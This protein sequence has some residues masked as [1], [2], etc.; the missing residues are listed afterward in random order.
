[1]LLAA[2]ALA[3]VVVAVVAVASLTGGSGGAAA[4]P[5]SS[6]PTTSAAPEPVGPQPG[7]RTVLDGR[8]FTLEQVQV[9]DT[10]V[11][12]SYGD[13]ADFFERTDCAGLARALWSTDVGGRTVVVAVS[14]VQM[15]DAGGARELRD[16]ADR[17]GSGNVSDLLREGVTYPG[18]PDG[19]SG[20]EYASAVEGPRV[21][22]VETSWV[23]PGAA[24][25]ADLDLVASTGL[26]L[27]MPDPAGA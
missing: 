16:L 17:N 23:A 26:G 18:A 13:V 8:A 7:D 19:L 1:M 14:S 2:A 12:N 6:T 20:A 25:T 10:C 21:T 27:P 5:P 9:D 15:G 24:G 11:G 3:L 22:I 4:A